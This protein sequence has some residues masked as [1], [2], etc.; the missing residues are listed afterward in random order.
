LAIGESASAAKP[1]DASAA[2]TPEKKP[3]AAA[4]PAQAAETPAKSR[5]DLT[6]ARSAVYRILADGSFDLLWASTS[7]TAFSIYAHQTG[8][9]VL[10][11]T[12]DKGRIYSIGNDGS[13]TLAL[14]TDADQI[15][16]I[17]SAGGSLLA[18]S[19]NQGSLYKIGPDTFS[20]GTYD[21]S[22]LDAKGTAAWGRIWW[23][24]SGNVS[25]QTRSGNTED[26]NETW[27]SWSNSLT[28]QR[29]GQIASPKARYL[30]W[31]AVLKPSAAQ[32]VLSE[33]NAAFVANNI[34]P[35][36]LSVQVL[37]TNIGLAANAAAPVDP[38]IEMTGLDPA[39][40]GIPNVTPPPRRVY[41][42]GATSLQ[43]TADDRNGDKLIFDV[44]YKEISDAVFKLL[45]SDVSENFITIDGQS[46]ADGRYVF[47]ILARDLP[48]NPPS[49]A[50]AGEKVTEPVDIDNTPPI[51]TT[52]GQPSVS[53][54][55]ARVAFDAVDAASYLTHAEY[56]VNGGDWTPIYSEDGI[57]DGPRERYSFDVRLPAAGE[58]SV[59][60]R[61]YDVNG[62]S[63]NSRVVV[64]R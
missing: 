7:V 38:N 57:S 34:A 21:S 30:Q 14:Q 64:R 18:T 5:Y 1:A 48:S 39:L 26:P 13:E 3:V 24:G 54:D 36:V 60:I 11:G 58:Y 22:V 47:K 52:A 51:V 44:Y 25:I 28:D 41:Q 59:T 40:F 43:W 8:N 33:V 20:E 10:I 31:R 23:R 35:E 4:K 37:P 46:L 53:G 62:N 2:A 63:G 27:S 29:G 49:L 12:S 45:R 19:S 61:V 15:S 6:G 9:G 56:S 32:A 17:S 55:R 16:T 50:L 42:R